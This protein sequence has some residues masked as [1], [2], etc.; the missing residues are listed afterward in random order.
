VDPRVAVSAVQ[1]GLVS[2]L[3][4]AALAPALL[5]DWVPDLRLPALVS[6][7][8]PAGPWHVAPAGEPAGRHTGASATGRAA[9]LAEL[10]LPTVR[11]VSQACAGAGR[12]APRVLV[13]NAAS[14][15]V[16]G[17]AVLGRRH[18]DA[19]PEADELVRALLD[20][21]WLRDGGATGADGFRRSGCCLFYRLPGHGLCPDC[22]L[23][24]PG[25][26]TSGH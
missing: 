17:A 8:P 22:V 1:V 16:G 19:A 24:R 11:T 9:A 25:R 10:V 4:S 14:A 3:W 26:P 21:P 6:V 7:G 15:L 12:T 23:V 5:L 2:R 18:P 13:S 20:D